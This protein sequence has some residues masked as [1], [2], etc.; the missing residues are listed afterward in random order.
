LSACAPEYQ[1]NSDEDVWLV[2]MRVEDLSKEL[3]SLGG[4]DYIYSRYNV[5]VWRHESAVHGT[6]LSQEDRESVHHHKPQAPHIGARFGSSPIHD[7][8]KC[9][10]SSHDDHIRGQNERITEVL[11][12]LLRECCHLLSLTFA[13]LHEHVACKTINGAGSMPKLLDRLQSSHCI[14]WTDCNGEVNQ[15][16]WSICMPC[17][18]FALPIVNTLSYPHLCATC[19]KQRTR[20]VHLGI[21]MLGTIPK[22]GL[23]R[24]PTLRLSN[25]AKAESLWC[26]CDIFSCVAAHSASQETERLSRQENKVKSAPPFSSLAHIDVGMVC[27]VVCAHVTAATHCHIDMKA[28]T[29]KWTER[30]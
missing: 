7:P 1:L 29:R 4:G 19:Y 10:G 27:V 9:V 16:V 30:M 25:A 26:T 28:S 6:R 12:P 5:V 13:D 8:Q 20:K 22:S 11:L 17:S 23:L 3:D 2:L 24:C 18:P 14:L 15:T 21:I